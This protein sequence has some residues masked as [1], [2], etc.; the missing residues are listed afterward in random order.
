MVIRFLPIIIH[1]IHL[2]RTRGNLQFHFEQIMAGVFYLCYL[3]FND[4]QKSRQ[5]QLSRYFDDSL[6]EIDDD[7]HQEYAERTPSRIVLIVF[8]AD[9]RGGI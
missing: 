4:Y 7:Y 2:V 6:N 5:N 9:G 8:R 1:F 3:F